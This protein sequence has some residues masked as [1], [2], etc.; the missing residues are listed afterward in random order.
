[1]SRPS[2]PDG[3]PQ[4]DQ[5]TPSRVKAIAAN[6]SIRLRPRTRSR[7]E[8]PFKLAVRGGVQRGFGEYA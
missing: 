1:V 8:G 5:R 3:S 2:P 4:P 6:A 7:G